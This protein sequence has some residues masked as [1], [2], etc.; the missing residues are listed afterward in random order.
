MIVLKRILAT[1]TGGL[2]CRPG[3][4][5]KTGFNPKKTLTHNGGF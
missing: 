4:D 2:F 1:V 3:D 5:V